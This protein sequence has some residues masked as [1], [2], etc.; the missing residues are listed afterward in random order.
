MMD[1]LDAMRL[2]YSEPRGAF[3]LWTNSVI[4]GHPC[5]RAVVPAVERGPRADLPGTGFGDQWGGYLR[6]SLLQ[7]TDLIREALVRMQ[8]VVE[9]YQFS[10]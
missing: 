10:T 5:Y 8:P 3:F 1:G 9:R 6:I 2:D 4:H 7:S